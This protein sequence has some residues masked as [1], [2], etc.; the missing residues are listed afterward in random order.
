M[1]LKQ[2]RKDKGLKQKDMA[3]YLDCTVVT[4][5]RYESGE[6]EPSIAQLR[7]LS[8]FFGVSID[9]LLDNR[10]EEEFTLSRYEKELVTAA[11]QSD[12]RGRTDALALLR[13]NKAEI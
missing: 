13:M 6:R 1:S 2:L 11:R 8:D 12:E 5:Q 3:R 4:Y 10:M 9:R 7:Q